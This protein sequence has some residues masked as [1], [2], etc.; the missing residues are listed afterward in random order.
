[1]CWR[2]G[3]D[4]FEGEDA[5][6]LVDFLAGNFAANDATEEAIARWIRRWWLH[7]AEDITPAIA[8]SAGSWR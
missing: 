7:T 1:M 5:I 6:V 2:L 3:I 8:L 4:V